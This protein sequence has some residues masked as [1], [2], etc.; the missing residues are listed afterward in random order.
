FAFLLNA[1]STDPKHRG[2]GYG[3]VKNIK[4]SDKWQTVDVSLSELIPTTHRYGA[5][6]RIVTEPMADWTHIT[7]FKLCTKFIVSKNGEE[8]QLG[9]GRWNGYYQFRNL[10]WELSK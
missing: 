10:R 2:G 6:Y 1:W 4:G 8:I 3:T 5:E 9:T 7:D